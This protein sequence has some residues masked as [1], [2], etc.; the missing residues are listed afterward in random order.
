MKVRL[1]AV[2]ALSLS[3]SVWAA[4]LVETLP[5]P[6]R[7]LP[8]LDPVLRTAA[9][10]SPRMVSRA[11]DLEI[12]ENNRI[13]ARSALL[14]NVGGSARIFETRDD[15][16]DLADPVRV[17]K[18]YYDFALN[19]PIFH[20][21]ERRNT[22]RIGEIQKFMADGN[23]REAYRGLAQEIRAKYYSLI[24]QKQQV[25]R[26]REAVAYANQQVKLFEDRLAKKVIS[27]IEIASVRLNAEQSQITFER[28]EFEFEMS[29]QSFARVTG[30]PVLRDDQIPDTM[31]RLRHDPTA[32]DQ[33][34][35]GFLS[36]K[37]LPTPEAVNARYSRQISELSL[38]NEKTRLRPKF[39]LSLGA[40][41]D[42]QAYTINGAQ[43]YRVNS[44]YAGVTI[45]WTV[46]D[47][48]ASQAA[49]RNAFARLRQSEIESNEVTNR[50]AQQAQ[51]QA[52]LINF[53]A[54]SMAISD[55]A[56]ESAEGNV[57]SKVSEFQRG[58]ISETDVALARIALIDSRIATFASRS[59]FLGRVTDF[60][61]TLAE[62]PAMAYLPTK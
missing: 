30:T 45:S 1:F 54:R 51:Q 28:I 18:T 2:V 53:A 49:K 4:S 57:A 39:S 20:W 55:R 62:D 38:Q 41:Q 6:E 9:Q 3:G 16:A 27:E 59:D 23:Y 7:V 8:G 26:W 44:L 56:L 33:M 47:G 46:F 21:G 40:N 10:Q 60:L 29:K 61:G 22:A 13:Q 17:Q 15:R 35:A 25:A 31:P 32:V 12:A 11:L 36:R 43:K 58:I 37:E 42:E 52:K 14:P 5:L 34:L 48:F 19:Q 50:L 24:V